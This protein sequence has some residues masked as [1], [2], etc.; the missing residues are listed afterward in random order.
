M[1]GQLR[2]FQERLHEANEEHCH[3]HG[4][5]RHHHGPFGRRWE[6][7][8]HGFGGG[9][10]RFFEGGDLRLVILHLIDEKPSYGYELMKAIE[11]RLMGGYAPSPGVVYPTLTM[12]EEEGLAT[13]SASEGNKKMYAA[14]EAGKEYL[15]ANSVMVKAIFGRMEKARKVFGRGRSP[16]IMRALMN[17]RVA[18]KMR[19]ERGDLSAE[20][21]S[22]IAAAIDATARTIDE[23]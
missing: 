15:K 21:V 13:V 6:G 5:H 2:D 8:E 11:E 19:A 3:E 9:R 20:Q 7:F 22:K 10:E 23:A 14:T 16:Q 18:L 12:L 1:F 4:R 17:L